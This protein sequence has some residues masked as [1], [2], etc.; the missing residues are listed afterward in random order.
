[1]TQ[2]EQLKNSWKSSLLMFKQGQATLEVTLEMLALACKGAGL[3]FVPSSLDIG[4]A[5]NPHRD[6]SFSS[7]V[8]F[9]Q[10]KFATRDTI[11]LQI[12]EIE[13]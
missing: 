9:D 11:N 5:V 8:A 7:A 4:D 6:T 2:T 1:M 10:G 13:L 12:E 3:K